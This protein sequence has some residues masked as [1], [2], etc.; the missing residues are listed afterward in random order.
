MFEEN[1]MDMRRKLSHLGLCIFLLFTSCVATKTEIEGDYKNPDP[2][3]KI[4]NEKIKP[5]DIINL[6]VVNREFKNLRVLEIDSTVMLVEPIWYN[7]SSG[8][9]HK[10]HLQYIQKIEKADFEARY[11]VGVPFVIMIIIFYLLA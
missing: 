11:P 5:G 6:T 8:N 4:A 2:V 9:S 1:K 3:V 7:Y 10:V